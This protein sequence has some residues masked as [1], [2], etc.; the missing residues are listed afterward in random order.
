MPELAALA[1]MGDRRMSANP[2]ANGGS[3]VDLRPARTSATTPCP[4]NSG[5]RAARVHAPAREDAPRHLRRATP[6]STTSAS[7]APTRRTLTVSATCSRSRTAASS[8]GRLDID[9]HLS[10]NGRVMEVLSEHLCEGWLEGY[11]L[12]G[13]HGLFATY[14]AFAMVSA[15]M[16]VQH[17]KWLQEASAPSVARRRR[18][19]STILLTSTCWRNDH[20]GFSHQG[21]GFIDVM[22]V[23]AGHGRAH[24]LAAGRKLPAVRRRPLPAQPGL[25]QPHRDRQATAASSTS[26]SSGAIEHSPRGRIDLARA[27][28]EEAASRTSSSLRGGHPPRSRR[29]RRRGGCE[30]SRPDL[31]VRVRQRG[32][33]DAALPGRVRTPRDEQRGA[34]SNSS[35]ATRPSSLLSTATSG[36]S[37]RSCTGNPTPDRFHVRGFN[38]QGTTTTPFQMV[39][40][41]S[42][43]RFHLAAEA[44]RRAP[45]ERPSPRTHCAV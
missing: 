4:S 15:S 35:P 6:S 33:P 45:S 16:T 23:K 13:R 11:L 34:S 7:S 20:N 43:S 29:W 36:R 10:P 30:S 32:R 2:H 39:V 38:E 12:T 25:R 21:P 9:D 1:P 42:M 27:G 31:R 41:N 8:A 22:L 44:I 3:S 18:P 28:S 26:T 24:L 14:E 40:L 19:R 5:Q 37:T 17:T